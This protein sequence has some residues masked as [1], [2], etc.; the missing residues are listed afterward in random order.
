MERFKPSFK[1]FMEA[2]HVVSLFLRSMRTEGY[3]GKSPQLKSDLS[4]QFDYIRQHES[5]IDFV[6]KC[7]KMN[8]NR[9]KSSK[10][11]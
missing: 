4:L 8:K 11:N 2:S 9:D 3:F 7:N 6:E 10:K 5:L 1:E